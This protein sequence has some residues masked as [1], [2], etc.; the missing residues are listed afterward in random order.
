MLH[1]QAA[2]SC[3]SN[4]PAG[5][6]VGLRED[7]EIEDRWLVT[8]ANLALGY[9]EPGSHHFTALPL[10]TPTRLASGEA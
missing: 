2:S 10:S 8:F 4:G 5:E 9:V 7:N 1:L 6:Y 3:I